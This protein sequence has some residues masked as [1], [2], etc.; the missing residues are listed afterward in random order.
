MIKIAPSI[1]GADF[2]NLE[3]E[4]KE[5]EELN[6]EILHLDMMDG[7]FV[8]NITFGPDQIKNLRPKSK[9]IFDVHMMVQDPDRFIPRIAEAGADIITIHQEATTHLHRSIQLIKSTGVK[10]GVV[11]NPA[12]PPE[13]LQ[14]ILEDIHMVLLMTVNPGYGGQKFIPVMT[15]KIAKTR[16]MISSYP[17][18]LQVDGGINDVTAKQCIEAGA[19]ILVAGSYVFNGDKKENIRKLLGEN[20]R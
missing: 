12:T 19:N 9:M 13:T 6:I 3:R 11:L 14:Y 7:N 18:D 20:E 15:E 2:G 8:P 5:L 4:I 16:E 1:L 17:I 10:A